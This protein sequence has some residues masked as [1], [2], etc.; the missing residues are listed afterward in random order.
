MGWGLL[1]PFMVSSLPVMIPVCTGLE[2]C[3]VFEAAFS[4]NSSRIF[5]FCGVDTLATLRITCKRFH[6]L[7]QPD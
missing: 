1:W 6:D 4:I 7:T 2:V 5:K 3:F